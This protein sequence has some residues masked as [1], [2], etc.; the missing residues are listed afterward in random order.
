MSDEET[1]EEEVE[2]GLPAYMGTFADLMALL[3]C[4]FVL[5]LS[6][7]E[8]DAMRFKRLAGSMA[9]AFGVQ[10]KLNVVDVPKGTSII[11]QQFSPGTPDPTPL[12]VIF[13]K[14]DDT[15]E[16]TLDV[17]CSEEYDVEQGTEALDQGSK[18]RIAEKL[19]EMVAET[20][21]DAIDLA[22]SLQAQIANG[23]VEIETNGRKII[24]RIR[25]KGSFGSGSARLN[26]SY[27]PVLAKVKGVLL[28]KK[29]SIAI[30]G[31]TDDIPIRTARFRSNWELSSSRAVSVAQELLAG[32]GIEPTRLSVGGFADTRPLADNET[33]EN[34]SKNRRVEIVIQQPLDQ[35]S[36]E[37]AKVLQAE[38]PELYK[39]LDL[40]PI[41]GFD[42]R[43]DE[44]F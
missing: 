32:D 15:T 3:M 13:Q 42:L 44:V 17:D 40:G 27:I 16:M 7:S 36:S 38:D 39:S 19:Q 41:Q 4:F 6:F 12:E 1:V 30:Q 22:S 11:A 25:E 9:Q 20:E 26:D 28:T 29:G 31:H 33:P 14:T 37:E 34:R 2:E 5:L 35:K 8:M 24:I 10:A 43:P 21:Q 23:E 18:A